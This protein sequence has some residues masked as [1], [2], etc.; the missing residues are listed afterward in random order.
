LKETWRRAIDPVLGSPPTP[1]SRLDLYRSAW[2]AYKDVVTFQITSD[3]RVYVAPPARPKSIEDMSPWER[4]YFHGRILA[5]LLMMQLALRHMVVQEPS[6]QIPNVTLVNKYV[7]DC[8]RDFSVN[9]II[10]WADYSAMSDSSH[11]AWATWM[12]SNSNLTMD[13]G[14]AA[15]PM[16]G[17]APILF[18]QTSI[19]GVDSAAHCHGLSMPN[20]DWVFTDV[21][22]LLKVLLFWFTHRMCAEEQQNEY[23][24]IFFYFLVNCRL[25]WTRRGYGM[26]TCLH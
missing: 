7:D 1:I 18:W 19:T 26:I 10:D 9:S 15:V 11:S 14:P 17:F 21:S 2:L 13:P 25:F 8:F 6:V 12:H 24:F 23:F 4:E 20:Y 22:R 5:S 3:R 16:T